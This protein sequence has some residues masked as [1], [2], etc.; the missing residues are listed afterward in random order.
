MG[1]E[2]VTRGSEGQR[3]TK[4]TGTVKQ[5][6]RRPLL[7]Q[8]ARRASQRAFCVALRAIE[9]I[10]CPTDK[11]SVHSS[12]EERRGTKWKH[13]I[14]FSRRK[15][16]YKLPWRTDRS[17]ITAGPAATTKNKETSCRTVSIF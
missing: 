16:A 17:T 4:E 1:Q 7:F 10:S 11:K 9:T 6:F 13:W 12:F 8:E 2:H 3:E 15:G 5:G 14:N